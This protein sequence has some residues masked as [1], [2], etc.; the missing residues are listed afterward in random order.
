MTDS[1]RA[2]FADVTARTRALFVKG[3]PVVNGVRGRLRFELRATW[4]GGTRILDKLEAA[5]YDMLAH[6]PALSG[7]DVPFILWRSARWRFRG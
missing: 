4:L 7:A 6:R 2:A 1:W 5:N 3:I